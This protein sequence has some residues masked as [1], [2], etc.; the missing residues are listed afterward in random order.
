MGIRISFEEC[1]NKPCNDCQFMQPLY[2]GVRAESHEVKI[3]IT[4]P[5]L[6]SGMR[7]LG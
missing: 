1:G 3:I 6:F 4:N 2:I 5:Q 7:S